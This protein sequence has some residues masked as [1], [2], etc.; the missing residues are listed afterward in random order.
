MAHPV[1]ETNGIDQEGANDRWIEAL[2]VENK[3]GVV[4]TRT[5]VH[6]ESTGTCR[7]G[8]IAEIGRNEALP[9]HPRHI[10]MRKSSHRSTAAIRGQTRDRRT[11]QQ[12]RQQ[13]RLRKDPRDEFAVFEVVAGEGGFVFIEATLNFVHPLV[14]IID[15]LAFTQHALRDM[16][17]AE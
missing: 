8:D 9:M 6:H 3:D 12:E 1:N 16:L 11:F 7:A 15:S 14:R 13:L 2:I 10:Q 17:E 5:R 4:K